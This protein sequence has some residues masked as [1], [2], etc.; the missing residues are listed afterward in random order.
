MKLHLKSVIF[1]CLLLSSQFSEAQYISLQTRPDI[2]QPNNI[3]NY[4]MQVA[5]DISDNALADI[6]SLADWKEIRTQRY[7]E[8]LE[9][10][11]LNYMPVN[12]HR[13]DLN[14][15]ITG[16][17]KQ[18]GYKIE[19]LYYESLPGLYVTANLYIPDKIRKPVPA[20]LY[21]C[22]HGEDQ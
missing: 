9:S 7:N 8:F 22:G 12:G 18:K 21:V 13:P 19:K 5:S 4:L 14:V 3:R 1:F 16:T 11:G 10:M 15:H 20:I 2:D 17:I 6:H